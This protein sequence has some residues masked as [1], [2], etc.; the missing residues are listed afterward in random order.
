M[1]A[2]GCDSGDT[3][4]TMPEGGSA[5][6]PAASESG[7]AASKE[8]SKVYKGVSSRREREKELSKETP[9]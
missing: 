9:R 7:Q 8:K 2:T 4:L 1:A 5:N 6:Q 3:V